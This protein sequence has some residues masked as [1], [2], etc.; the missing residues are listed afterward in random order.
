MTVFRQPTREWRR[1]AKPSVIEAGEYEAARMDQLC[2]QEDDVNYD[3]QRLRARRATIS[4]LQ[5]DDRCDVD[6]AHPGVKAT[7][8]AD[9]DPRHRFP[10]TRENSLGQRSRGAGDREHAAVM[11]A[12]AV[13]VEH[14]RAKGGGDR[15]NG[16]L[17]TALRQV[18]HGQ[19]RDRPLRL[20]A[21]TWEPGVGHAGIL[22]PGWLRPLG[23]REPSE[24]TSARHPPWANPVEVSVPRLAY[25]P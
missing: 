23:G 19:E 25:P 16:G 9:V 13:D 11:I 6:R 14:A 10:G 24:E 15:V 3:T 1:P 7:V 21:H 17:V 18:G 20:G 12:V 5:V 8:G 2:P 22:C 4:V